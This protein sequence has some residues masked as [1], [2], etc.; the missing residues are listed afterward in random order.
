MT[1]YFKIGKLV[2]VYGLKGELILKHNLGKKTSLKGLQALFIEDKKDSFLPWFIQAAKI[3]SDTELYI[4][5]E[6]IESREAAM[7]LVQKE[8]WLAEN[9]FKKFAARSAPVSLLGYS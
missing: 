4:K 8:T 9:D 7:K 1:E 6:G 3:K 5:L 2:A